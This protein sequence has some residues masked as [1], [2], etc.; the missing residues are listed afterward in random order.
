VR[1]DNSELDQ[2]AT[3]L[4][5][6]RADL[7]T[8]AGRLPPTRGHPADAVDAIMADPILTPQEK[9]ALVQLLILLRSR[10]ARHREY[11]RQPEQRPV[12]RRGR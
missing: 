2:L 12:A 9:A 5:V 3:T 1:Q 10:H 8:A 7:Y 4:A 6:P 11:G